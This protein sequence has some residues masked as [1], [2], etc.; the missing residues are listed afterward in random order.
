MKQT[1]TR[2]LLFAAD[3]EGIDKLQN[4][5]EQGGIGKVEKAKT[6]E[7]A[8]DKIVAGLVDALILNLKDFSVKEVKTLEMF[9]SLKPN[10]AIV[11]VSRH[12]D[13]IAYDLVKD[14]KNI[15]LV[16]R[17]FKEAKIIALLCKRVVTTK[18]PFKREHWRYP[19]S[20]KSSIEILSNQRVHWGSVSNISRGGAFFESTH[21]VDV[22]ER[23]LIRLNMNLNEISKTHVINTEVAWI[24]PWDPEAKNM[25]LGLK[26]IDSKDITELFYKKL[27]G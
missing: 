23:E 9:C 18:D 22:I 25:G 11:A 13:E 4:E 5:I 17:P 26:F 2:F 1:L 10:L 15:I 7:I 3:L 8:K 12:V 21:Q 24:A 27:K 19:T 20:Q 14:Q 6:L 16:Q